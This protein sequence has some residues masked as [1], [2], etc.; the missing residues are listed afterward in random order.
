MTP[1][2]GVNQLPVLDSSLWECPRTD[3]RE[4]KMKRKPVRLAVVSMVAV[5]SVLGLSQSPATAK[6][7]HH[8][9]AKT[10]GSWCC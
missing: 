4:Q 6:T 9:A 3:K 1:H 10:G 5:L 8:S 2:C 7:I